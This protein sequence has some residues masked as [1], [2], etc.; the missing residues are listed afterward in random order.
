MAGKS[1]LTSRA[2]RYCVA[3]NKFS[4]ALPAQR[5]NELLDRVEKLQ[6]AVKYAREEAN[7]IEAEEPKVGERIF[8]YLFG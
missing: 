3:N 6:Q 2:A 4:G 8:N 7:N 1:I 5:V